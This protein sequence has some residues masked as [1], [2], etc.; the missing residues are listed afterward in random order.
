MSRLRAFWNRLRASGASRQ[1]DRDFEAEREAH[2]RLAADDYERR[3]LDPAAARRQAQ[4]AFGG[5]DAAHELQ[6]DARGFSVIEAFWRDFRYAI[7]GLRR[8]PGLAVVAVLILAIGI[9]ANTAVFSLVRPILLKPLPFDRPHELVWIA[10]SGRTGLSGATLQVATFEALRDRSQSFSDWTAYFAFFGYGNNTLTGRGDPERVSIVDVAPRFLELLGVQP[11]MGRLFTSEEYVLNAPAAV[12]VSHEYWSRRF[13]ADRTIVGTHISVNER[14]T[15]VAGILPPTFDF[16]SVF[17]PGTRVDFVKPAAL[18]M[19][20]RS[21]NTLSLIGRL[22]PGV[23]I[24]SARAEL[25]ALAPAIRAANRDIFPF[26][27][28]LTPLQEQVSGMMRRPLY[29]LWGAVGLVLLIVCANVSN[30]LLARST[31]RAKE[32]AVRLALGASR[33]R[34]FQQLALEGIVLSCLG[35]ALGIPLAYLLT[36]LVKQNVTLAV[37]LLYQAG[38]DGFVL[39]VTAGLAIATGFVFS[40]LPALRVSRAQPQSALI[41][42]NRGTTAGRRHAWIRSSLVVAELVIACVLLVGTGLLLKSFVHLLD[43]DLGFRP[44]QSTVL[45]LRIGGDRTREQTTALLTEAARRVRQLPAVEAAGLTDALPLDRNRSWGVG[46]PGQTYAPGTRPGGFAL[47]RRARVHRRD[48][49]DARGGPRSGGD[50]PPHDGAGR[51]GQPI[52]GSRAVPGPGSDRAHGADLWSEAAHHRR[53]RRRRPAKQ[54]GRSDRATDVHAVHARRR[55]CVR[56]GDA[57]IDPA[58]GLSDED[59]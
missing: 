58:I 55:I 38:V 56:P 34:L 20:R 49:H 51:P 2:L 8:E 1:L 17:T 42:Q 26:A 32:F 14:P 35:G 13:G 30:L 40:V 9:G 50:G 36:S 11:A 19:F 22:K 18:D 33:R 46:V 21:G 25:E 4:L 7:R 45:T 53:H 48:G 41:D 3:G 28:R 29:V 54:S 15:L 43:A 5:R 44:A 27:T 52:A 31:A 24:A 59:P 57:I 12:L 23:S 10:N 6:R 37:P 16:A 39:L 47:H